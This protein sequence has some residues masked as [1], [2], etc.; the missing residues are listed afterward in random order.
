MCNHGFQVLEQIIKEP[1]IIT[2][3][4]RCQNKYCNALIIKKYR[5]DDNCEQKELFK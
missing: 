1:K 3:Y 2:K 5:L 4:F